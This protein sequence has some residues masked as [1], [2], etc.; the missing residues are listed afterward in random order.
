MK[1]KN[2]KKGQ[3]VQVKEHREKG[4]IFTIGDFAETG[5][6]GIIEYTDRS[7]DNAMVYFLAQECSWSCHANE[8]RKV[9]YD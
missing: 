1:S 5:E 3:V 4:N 8:L 7:N 2:L 6:F 9:K